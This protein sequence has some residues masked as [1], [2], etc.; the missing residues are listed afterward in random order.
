MIRPKGT[1]LQEDI[2]IFLHFL[3]DRR[4]FWLK[5]IVFAPVIPV[6]DLFQ[7]LVGKTLTNRSIPNDIPPHGEELQFLFKLLSATPVWEVL[8]DFGT[9][10]V[11]GIVDFLCYFWLKGFLFYEPKLLIP[12]H[13]VLRLLKVTKS[14]IVHLR[15]RYTLDF[16]CFEVEGEVLLRL[17]HSRAS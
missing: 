13:P 2:P 15:K 14:L 4:S 1:D 3:D 7:D 10:K 6:L 16:K 17:I 12:L 8:I 11:Q 5:V 9:L